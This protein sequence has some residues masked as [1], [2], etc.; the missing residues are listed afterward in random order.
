MYKKISLALGV[1][2]FFETLYCWNFLVI[3]LKLSSISRHEYKQGEYMCGNYTNEAVEF[4]ANKNIKSYYAI[5]KD[6]KGLH[7]WLLVGYDVQRNSLQSLNDFE[8]IDVCDKEKCVCGG[9]FTD[10]NYYKN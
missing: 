10:L 4:L 5:G 7:S 2:L 9:E 6:E 3:S 1:L 8:L